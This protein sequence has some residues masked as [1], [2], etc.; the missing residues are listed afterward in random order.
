MLSLNAFAAIAVIVLSL[1]SPSSVT[2]SGIVTSV[3]LSEVHSHLVTFA[4]P[5]PLAAYVII[6]SANAEFTPPH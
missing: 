2:F 6:I 3:S 4:K 5:V 1:V